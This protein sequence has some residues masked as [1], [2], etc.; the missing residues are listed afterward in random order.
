MGPADSDSLSRVESYS[1]CRSVLVP[2]A[3][4]TFTPCGRPFQTV[5]LG[6][7]SPKCGP[8]TPAGYPTG[9]GSSAFARRYSRSRGFFLLL[10]V[11]RCFSSL[12]S[13][14]YS[15]IKARLTAPPDFS[16]S[17]TPF[18]LLVPRHPPHALTSLAALLPPSTRVATPE[19]RK[20]L[21]S[22]RLPP[23]RGMQT[24]S[25]M[26]PFFFSSKA[27]VLIATACPTT[28]GPGTAM[29]PPTRSRDARNR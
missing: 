15:G 21:D 28:T 16:Q 11:M 20:P 5:R 7:R 17:S 3:Y 9:L 6:T 29:R 24:G 25:T 12:G 1:G 18:R 22:A 14:G 26:L 2:V 27:R 10:Q 19:E 23:V 13:L 8:T 4:G